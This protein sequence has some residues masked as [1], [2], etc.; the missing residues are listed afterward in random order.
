[1]NTHSII[2]TTVV[3]IFCIT[4][5]FVI[6]GFRP[7][8]PPTLALIMKVIPDVTK[9]TSASD[10]GAAGKSDQLVAGDQVRTGKHA[11]AVLKFL[12]RSIV[13][14]REQSQI[15]IGSE[16]ATM[17][18]KVV[19]LG[20]GAV[21]FDIKKQIDQQFRFT[22][23]TSVASIRGTKGKWSGGLGNDTLVV[24][25]GLVNLKNQPSDKNIDVPAG[26][27]GFSGQDGSLSSRL[28]TAQ[29]LADATSAATTGGSPNELNLEMR[30]SN[31]NKKDLKI[32]FR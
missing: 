27:I 20:S 19:Q 15:T 11:L 10:W 17:P 8:S 21:G 14:V 29:E 24:T 26:Y 23:P 28:A 31:G 30:D 1:M 5:V 3:I 13:R 25:E 2:T 6:A 16:A 12:D 22:S 9:K 32:K 18:I 4:G 7:N